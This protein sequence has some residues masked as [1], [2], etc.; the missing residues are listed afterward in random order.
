LRAGLP[1]GLDNPPSGDPGYYPQLHV[2]GLGAERVVDEV[3]QI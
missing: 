3:P 1:G 2:I